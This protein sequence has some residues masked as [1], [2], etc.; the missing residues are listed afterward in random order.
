MNLLLDTHVLLWALIDDPG[1][2]APARRAIVDGA[3]T[4][5]VSA[6]T[7][8]EIAIKK[9]LGKLTAPDNYE[10]ELVA[11][12]FTPL[13]LTTRHA[14]AVEKLPPHHQD[15]FDRLLIVQAQLER[16]TLVTRDRKIMDYDVPWI[17][18]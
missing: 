12:R 15:P 13:D 4:V 7:A 17:A 5:F 14:L 6:A 2:S 10:E 1:L 9:S 8:W 18:A 16:L 11:H 3:N